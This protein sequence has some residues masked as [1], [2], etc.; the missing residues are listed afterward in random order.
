MAVTSVGS[1]SQVISALDT[2]YT[3][4]TET[5]PGVY[6]LVVDCNVLAN[7]DTVVIRLYTKYASGG[8]SR[9]AYSQSFSNVQVE[10]NKYS[11]AV[12]ID[13]ELVAKIEQTDGTTRTFPWNL[14]KIS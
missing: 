9:V 10:V 2:E 5:D 12:P 3:L 6:V 4:D 7:G 11:P 1:G 8:T 13:T 14:L